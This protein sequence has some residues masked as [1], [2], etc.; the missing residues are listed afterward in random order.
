MGGKTIKRYASAALLAVLGFG[1][2]L[3]CSP[4]LRANAYSTILQDN[5]AVAPFEMAPGLYYVG[6]SDIAVFAL[7]TAD[8]IVVI[9]GGY[10]STARQVLSNLRTLGLEPRDVRILLNTHGHVDHAAGLARLKEE[11]GAALYAGPGD[12]HLLESGGRGDFFLGDWM[13]YPPVRVDRILADGEAVTLGALTLT[14]HFTPGHTKGCTSWSFPIIADGETRQALIVCS[15]ATLQ[16]DLTD[17][18]DYP[19]IA[20][21]FAVTFDRLRALPCEVFLG[22]HAKFFDMRAKRAA[23]VAGASV[24]P[25]IDPVGCRAFIDREDVRF[26][27]ALA[28]QY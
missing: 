5:R 23:Q 19:N 27:Q 21:D 8:G 28:R 6:S 17:N 15:L 1:A 26:G 3:A 24:N 4:T 7:T 14:P 25:F 18:P 9:D 22:D 2:V 20:T 10:D 11:T 12:A 13:S 16:Y